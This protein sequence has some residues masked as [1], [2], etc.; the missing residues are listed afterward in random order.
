MSPL[1]IGLLIFVVTIAVLATG[2]P[3]AF[4]MGLRWRSAFMVM[5]D[6]WNSVHFVPETV[7]AGLNDFT[8]VSLPMFIIMGAAVASSRAGSDLY[9]ALA[10]WLHRCPA[11]W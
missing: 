10:R 5:F 11:R 9:E 1:A 3:I 2:M 7:F 8:L 4:G 6:G